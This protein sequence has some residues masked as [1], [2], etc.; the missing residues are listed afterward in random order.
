MFTY[1]PYNQWPKRHAADLC[2]PYVAALNRTA[3]HLRTLAKIF[4]ILFLE[5]PTDNSLPNAVED[6]ATDPETDTQR[7]DGEGTTSKAPILRSVAIHALTLCPPFD[8]TAETAGL[9]RMMQLPTDV[10]LSGFGT[11][12]IVRWN[13]SKVE[14]LRFTS[15][16]NGGTLRTEELLLV[17]N[18]THL[19]LPLWRNTFETTKQL[20]T[21]PNLKRLVLFVL[22]DPIDDETMAKVTAEGGDSTNADVEPNAQNAGTSNG[23]V[24]TTNQNNSTDAPTDP[25]ASSA[26]LRAVFSES[27]ALRGIDDS[28]L[29][30]FN[31]REMVTLCRVPS[32]RFWDEVELRAKHIAAH[33][34]L[35]K[36]RSLAGNSLAEA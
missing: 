30:L 33:V 11:S 36:L 16:V 31:I 8:V 22:F 28:R 2:L 19:A 26:S 23:E 13:F 32:H 18:L 35:G 7:E 12:N 25:N 14:R 6:N 15:V 34:V 4:P 17:P 21:S 20:L 24:A 3:P 5:E 27:A 10:T 29:I 9:A 1:L